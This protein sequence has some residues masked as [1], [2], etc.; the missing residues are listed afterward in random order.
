VPVRIVAAEY[1]ANRT[2]RRVWK[3]HAALEAATLVGM[4]KGEN[5]GKQLVKLV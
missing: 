4:L 1:C 2:Q 3:K 5:F